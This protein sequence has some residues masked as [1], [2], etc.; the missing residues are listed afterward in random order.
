MSDVGMLCVDC[1]AKMERAAVTQMA[2]RRK[3]LGLVIFKDIP[4][5]ECPSCGQQYFK[6]AVTE[7]MEAVLDGRIPPEGKTEVDTF[8]LKNKAA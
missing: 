3:G 7:M 1:G 2:S 5:L 6:G 8:S 4:C